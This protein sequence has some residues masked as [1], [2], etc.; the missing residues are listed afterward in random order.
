M[1]KN[2]EKE[3]I[4]RADSVCK[5]YTESSIV[6]H[7]LKGVDLDI[8]SDEMVAIIGSSGSGK[9][10][11]LHILGTL[12]KPTKGAVYYQGENLFKL[13]NARCDYFRN[14]I[15]GFVYQFH[16]LLSDFTAYENVAFPMMIS[17]DYNKKQIDERVKYLLDRVGLG[18][19]LNHRSSELS[20]GERACGHC[21]RRCQQTFTYSC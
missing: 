17:G 19:R 8:Y 10:T 12:D 5:D 16:H 15:L 13:G 9:S 20:G 21:P 2:L 18:H 11:L 6:T 7:V 4:L 1:S 14:H 3:L